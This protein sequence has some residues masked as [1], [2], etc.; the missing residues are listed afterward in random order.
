[1]GRIETEG[2][3]PKP[4]S[5]EKKPTRLTWR[6]VFV[7]LFVIVMV[8]TSAVVLKEQ[9]VNFS[10]FGYLG[11]FLISVLASATVVAF[12]PSVP[13]LFALGG[14]LNPFYVGLAAGAGEAIG[15]FIIYTAGR[16]GHA[17]FLKNRSIEAGNSRGLYPHLQRWV[18]ERGSLALF[19]SSAVF[20]PFFSLI[21][22]TAGATRF[23]A[24]K[25]LGVV[26]A[27]KTVKWTVVAILG[28][29]ILYYIIRWF[30]TGS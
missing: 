28:K 12:I 13:F 26:W 20:N 11:A 17:F 27:G 6:W 24:W 16:T 8:S 10:E 1:V 23:P 9:L 2:S 3:K 15:E 7:A 29:A 4:E 18:Q 5:L 30:N 21:S 22:A 19:L 14:V 25:F